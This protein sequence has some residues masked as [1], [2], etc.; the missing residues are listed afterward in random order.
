MKLKSRIREKNITVKLSVKI[1][2]SESKVWDGLTNPQIIKKYM[3]GASVDSEWKKGSKITWEGEMKGKKYEDKGEILEIDPTK[4]LMYSHFSPMSGEKDVPQNYHTV[5]MSLSGDNK[6]TTVYLSQ[7]KNKT[8][9]EKDES[10]KN[11]KMML[12]GLKKVLEE[13]K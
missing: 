12:D 6:Q 1:N 10:Q 7:D 9:K 5:T 13:E 3:M 2:A 8:E 11:W 4:K